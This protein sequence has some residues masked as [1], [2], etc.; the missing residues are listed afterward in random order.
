MREQTTRTP[1][2]SICE[3]KHTW[4]KFWALVVSCVLGHQLGWRRDSWKDMYQRAVLFITVL[5]DTSGLQ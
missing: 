3:A 5:L 2:Q 1:D 4:T